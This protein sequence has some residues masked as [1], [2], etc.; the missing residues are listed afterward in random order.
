MRC[1]LA[2]ITT[3]TLPLKEIAVFIVLRL[4]DS[5]GGID[6][7]RGY[8][9]L[10]LE[11][12]TYTRIGQAAFDKVMTLSSDFHDNKNSGSLWLSIARGQSIRHLVSSVLFQVVPMLV[13]LV[14]AISV[15][16]Y[17]FDVYMALIIAAVVVTFLWSAG[18]ILSLQKEKRRE[19][20]A[21]LQKEQDIL[22][23]ATGNWKTVSYFNKVPYE[24]SRYFSAMC[25]QM[26]SRLVFK[27]WDQVESVVQSFLLISGLM[28]ACFLAAYQVIQGNKPVGS[29]VMLLSYWAQLSAPLQFF[30]S[31][32]VGVILD[33]VDAEDL[34]VLL[35]QQPTVS[36]EQ[37]AK[38]MVL[39]N[40]EIEFQNVKF[41]YDNHRDVVKDTSFQISAGQTV[42]LVGE[43]GGG[44]STV[45][46]LISRFYDPKEG[47]IF[48]DGQ[49]I[50][51]VTLESLRSNIG[52]VPQD[53]TLFHDTIMNNIRYANFEASDDEIFE[54]CK[55]VALH[56]K[57]LSFSD[58]YQTLVGERGVKLS[59]GELQRVAIARAIVKNPKLV[60][61]D[62]ATSS[63]DSETEAQIQKSLGALTRGRT[64]LVIA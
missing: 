2:D 36:D 9:W 27:T 62:E 50:R 44:K 53:P 15:L 13:D 31:S 5:S 56:E 55:A 29:F 63:V 6:A 43:T 51:H 60:L 42:A 59:G 58:G 7:I 37:D 23:E 4:L 46:K 12:Y 22:C 30:A 48:I 38:Q 14:L 54:A 45:M 35:K 57:F 8:M 47:T 33:L 26:K 49:N 21:D 52:V 17:L 32:F 64:T 1:N 11:N 3:A 34:L 10:P 19:W 20:I 39:S 41:S 24:K 18:K 25:T 16:Y 28:G 61:L 40:G